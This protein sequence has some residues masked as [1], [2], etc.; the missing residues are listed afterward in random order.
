[1]S[2]TTRSFIISF[3]VFHV[4]KI[5]YENDVEKM[6]HF[7]RFFLWNLSKI[8]LTIFW[9]FFLKN[10]LLIYRLLWIVNSFVAR[11]LFS[12]VLKCR[13]NF[14]PLRKKENRLKIAHKGR[15]GVHL[16]VM[17]TPNLL[18]F[19][20]KAESR[21]FKKLTIRI[22]IEEIVSMKIRNTFDVQRSTQIS[23]FTRE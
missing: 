21:Y 3:T 1:M 23:S 5:E 18:L 19:A 2:T 22:I 11:I 20:V 10:R 17:S 12:D 16:Y 15:R 14:R 8:S 4:T 9:F 7:N 6:I 13:W